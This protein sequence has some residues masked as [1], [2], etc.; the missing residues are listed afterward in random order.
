[1]A[2]IQDRRR[3]VPDLLAGVPAGVTVRVPGDLLSN[4][5]KRSLA[6]DLEDAW[7]VLT[8]NSSAGLEALLAGVPVICDE[9]AY[10]GELCETDPR[11]V[12]TVELPSAI[13]RWELLSRLA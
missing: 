11:Q 4:A 10:Y 9:I 5:K 12:E 13:D 1:M 3:P 2:P 8:Y 6:E 7:C